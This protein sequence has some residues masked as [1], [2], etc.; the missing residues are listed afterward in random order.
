MPS[1]HLIVSLLPVKDDP[2]PEFYE[3]A[4]YSS[5]LTNLSAP[6][7][8]IYAEMMTV[9]AVSFEEAKKNMIEVIK[10]M[11]WLSWLV[12]WI[13]PVVDDYKTLR[14]IHDEMAL[15]KK[16]AD[17]ANGEFNPRARL[18]MPVVKS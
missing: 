14:K 2:F 16:D 15:R 9:E 8:I 5:P 10:G 4:I 7:G 3:A 17:D 13:D 12:P 18:K 1:A 11:P 6:P